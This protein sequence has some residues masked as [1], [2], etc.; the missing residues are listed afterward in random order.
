MSTP[1]ILIDGVEQTVPEMD[2]G[3][4]CPDHPALEPEVGF[5]LAGGGYGAYT[6]CSECGRILSKMQ[7]HEGE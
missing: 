4:R 6:Y 7:E 3:L 5:G 1:T 2:E